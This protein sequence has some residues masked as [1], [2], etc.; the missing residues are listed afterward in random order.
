MKKLSRWFTAAVVA[1]ACLAVTGCGQE[2]ST[3]DDENLYF[4]TVQSWSQGEVQIVYD[5]S[6]GVMY[7]LQRNEYSYTLNPLYNADG[8]LRVYDE[9]DV[10]EVQEENE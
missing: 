9:N 8:S 10:Q 7:L 3:V 5:K 1:A 4:K 2:A 6:T